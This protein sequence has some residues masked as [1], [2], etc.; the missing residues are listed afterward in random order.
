MMGK[1]FAVDSEDIHRIWIFPF[2][3]LVLRYERM[4]SA[5]NLKKYR[6]GNPARSCYYYIYIYCILF[7]KSHG[8]MLI[9]SILILQSL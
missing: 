7:L 2:A 3:N 9:H 5:K 6:S 1:T 4:L 8:S